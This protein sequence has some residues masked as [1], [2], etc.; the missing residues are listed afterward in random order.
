[1]GNKSESSKLKDIRKTLSEKCD[2]IDKILCQQTQDLVN[3]SMEALS[4][5]KTPVEKAVVNG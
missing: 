3:I 2:K 5:D 4:I 1:M